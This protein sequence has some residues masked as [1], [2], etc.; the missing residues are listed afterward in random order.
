MKR[1]EKIKK[2]IANSKARRALR[3]AKYLEKI[4][5]ARQVGY[6]VPLSAFDKNGYYKWL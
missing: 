2:K 4:Q 1:S 5:K 3:M 6:G